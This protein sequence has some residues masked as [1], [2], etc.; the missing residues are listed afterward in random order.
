MKRRFTNRLSFL[1]A[2]LVLWLV[3]ASGGAYA[4]A[5]KGQPQEGQAPAKRS[6]MQAYAEAM[7]PGWNLGNTFDSVGLGGSAD[8]S[9]ENET[10]WGNPVVTKSLIKKI[11]DQ[12]FKSIRIPITWEH[13]IGASPDYAIDP[14]YLDRIEQVVGWALDEK[15]YVMINLH[16]DSWR[17]IN[18]MG[19]NYDETLARYNA[20]W[21]QI[22]DRF[23]HAS[24]KLMF[25]SVNEPQFSSEQAAS[26]QEMLDTLNR[27][28]HDIVRASGGKNATRPL[29]LPTLHTSSDQQHLDALGELFAELDDPNLI[30]TIHYYG[31]WPFSVNIAGFTRFDETTRGE[32]D[33]TF[34]R[35]YDTFVSKGIPV[36]VGEF[37]LLGFDQHTGTIEQG[38]KLKFF[39][40]MLHYAQSKGI[41]HMLWDN[42]Q[43]FNRTTYKWNDPQLYDMMKASWQGRSATAVSDLVFVKQGEPI[44]DISV[45]LQPNGNKLTSLSINGKKLSRIFDYQIKGDV[46]TFK[47]SFLERVTKSGETGV[48]ATVTADFNKGADWQFRIV[49]AGTP[50][51]HGASGTTDAF[52]IPTDFRGDQLA[53]M[54]AVYADGS[55]AGPQNWTSFKEFSYTFQPSYDTGEILLKKNFFNEVKDGTVTL[56]FHFWSGEI[57]H[58]TLTKSGS[59]VTGMPAP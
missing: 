11:A 23:K 13:K 47:K 24:P 26:S 16:H 56:K 46:L 6:A 15:L 22:A 17:W 20:A 19:S 51:L 35:L 33:Q 48:R 57:V 45:Q 29:V 10:A 18:G 42:G 1:T 21:T 14:A 43:H 27:S 52:A 41:T 31:F 25:E 12:G 54:E 3:A 58:Y 50:I 39:E 32:I 28:F 36:V 30:A 2:L 44:A 37:G 40:Y 8:P 4:E 9:S 34:N 5:G 49:A 7:Q 53:T 59:G 55:N 38:E